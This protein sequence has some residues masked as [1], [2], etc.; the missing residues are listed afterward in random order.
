MTD[1]LPDLIAAFFRA[2]SFQPGGKPPYD[3][4]Y[5]LFIE[6]GLLIKND[7]SGPEISTLSRFIKP[8]LEMVSS[9]RLTSFREVELSGITEMFG[10]VAHRFST[11]EKSGTLDGAA[12]NTRGMISTQFIMTASGWKISA[13]AWEDE[14]R[15]LA[16]PER[17]RTD[18]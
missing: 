6:N 7:P 13:M 3:E 18:S 4:L 10:S 15:G 5:Q 16:I 8:R 2:V 1:S 14:R 12:F 11:Y 9:G 17:Y